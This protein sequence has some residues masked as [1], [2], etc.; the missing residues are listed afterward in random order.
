MRLVILGAGGYGKTVY[1]V[2]AQSGK[3]EEIFFLDDNSTDSRVVGK[4]ADF[5][6]YIS[7][8]TEIYPAF[9]NNNG[10]LDWITRLLKMGANVPTLVHP[11]S[12]ISPT[13][14]IGEGTVVLPKAVVNTD[15][16]IKRGVIVNCS[17]VIDHGCIIGNGVHVCLG[18]IVKAEN[19]IPDCMKIEAGEVIENRKY[20]LEC[21]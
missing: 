4:C 2:A 14:K 18:A 20:P 10:R 15:T 3:Y 21:E 1:D 13:V 17:A 9:G 7:D 8:E 16:E 11:T 12:Y 6:R 5:E 19:K